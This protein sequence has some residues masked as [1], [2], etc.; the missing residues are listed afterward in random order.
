MARKRKTAPTGETV[1][2]TR[3]GLSRGD[4]T[5][6]A[7]VDA[8]KR[9]VHHYLAEADQVTDPRYDD[10]MRVKHNAFSTMEPHEVAAA[11]LL[12]APAQM[13]GTC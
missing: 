4:A 5:H 13:F 11:I 8:A 12:E 10:L 3:P 6:K 2:C 1:I 9:A 7:M